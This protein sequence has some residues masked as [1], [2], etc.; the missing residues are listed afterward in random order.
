[1]VKETRVTLVRGSADPNNKHCVMVPAL[2]APR[3]FPKVAL[4]IAPFTFFR[5]NTKKQRIVCLVAYM[6]DGGHEVAWDTCFGCAQHIRKCKC[7]TI[8]ATPWMVQTIAPPVAP[9]PVG[10]IQISPLN[11]KAVGH[12]DTPPSSEPHIVKQRNPLKRV[13]RKN[14]GGL[15]LTRRR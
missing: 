2:R 1:M 5:W 10:P 8:T 12:D 11:Y 9:K 13:N 7:G 15:K 6:Q 4:D 14:G 3:K